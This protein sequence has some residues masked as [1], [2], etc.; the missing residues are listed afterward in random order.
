MAVGR[1]MQEQLSRREGNEGESQKTDAEHAK[2]AETL[3][4][5]KCR[6]K[7][8]CNNVFFIE[9]GIQER[10]AVVIR[11]RY[12]SRRHESKRVNRDNANG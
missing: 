10:M 3:S 11:A 12:L 2:N 5:K 1:T 7:C 4:V 8:A 9:R 6:L